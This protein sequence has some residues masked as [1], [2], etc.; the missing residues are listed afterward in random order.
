MTT[1][2][3]DYFFSVKQFSFAA[4]FVALVR[5]HFLERYLSV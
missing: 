3:Y 4:T 1:L 2:P 5:H